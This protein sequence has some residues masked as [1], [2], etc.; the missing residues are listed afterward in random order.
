M[1]TNLLILPSLLLTFEKDLLGKAM[2]EPMLSIFDE[3]EDIDLDE[4][5]IEGRSELQ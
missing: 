3:E 5:E 1:F 2:Q 4:L